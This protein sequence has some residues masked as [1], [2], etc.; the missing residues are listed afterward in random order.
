MRTVDCPGNHFPGQRIYSD[1]LSISQLKPHWDRNPSVIKFL[2]LFIFLLA[3][4]ASTFF[5]F[6]VYPRIA[7]PL[8]N[9]ITTDGYD[10]LGWGLYRYR[11]LVYFPNRQPTVMRGPVYPM[12]L[13]GLLAVKPAWFPGSVQFAQ[14]VVHGLTCL[15][16]FGISRILWDRRRGA[17]ASLVCS[18]H[19]Y[20]IWFTSRVVTETV[21]TFLFTAVV[22]CLVYFSRR[23]TVGRAVL[24]G[25]VLGLGALC[26]QT[27]LPFV[28]LMPVLLALRLDR[29]RR[30]RFSLAMLG[31]STLLILPW[32]VRNYSLTK[33]FVPVHAMLGFNLHV[34]DSFVENYGKSPLGYARLVDLISYP[35]GSEGELVTHAWFQSVDPRRGV[36]EDR[37][38][39]GKALRRY[40][41]DPAFFLRKLGLNGVMFWTLS[42]RP[43]ASIATMLMQMSLLFFFCVSAVRIVGRYGG[44]SWISMPIW[45]VVAYFLFHLPIYGLARFGVVLVPTMVVCAVGLLGCEG[46]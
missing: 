2:P 30:W 29:K 33:T 24:L 42:S 11:A 5:T 4:L 6:L 41:D 44:V 14:G 46:K 13:A 9:T 18:V 19:P 12:F 17:V 43:S 21:L 25:G 22:F 32:T 39:M 8:E 15:L 28:L 27:L 23:P 7:G 1:I 31:A 40:V 45:L 38:L 26:K 34:G 35:V 16:V 36:E 37:R 3:V 20:L 10:R